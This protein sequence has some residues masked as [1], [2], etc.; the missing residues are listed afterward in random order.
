MMIAAVLVMALKYCRA[1]VE[2]FEPVIARL[3]YAL[4]GGRRRLR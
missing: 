1:R 4:E 2:A 3:R